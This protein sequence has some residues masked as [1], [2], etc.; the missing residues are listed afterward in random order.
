VGT[1]P[2]IE[3]AAASESRLKPTERASASVHSMNF[4]AD[5][6]I[7]SHYSRATSKDLTLEHLWKWAQIKGVT[8]VATG[9]IAH[10]GWL[11]EMQREVGAGGA[12]AVPL[13]EEFAATVAADLPPTCRGAVRFLLGGEISN[14]Y[15]RHGKTR[16]VHNLIFAPDFDTVARLQTRLERIGNIRADGRPILGLDSRDLLEIALE[17]DAALSLHPRAHLDAVVRHARLD[18]GLRRGGGVLRRPDAAHLCAG[19]RAFLRPADE[20]ARL[21]PGPLHARL[22]LRR[23]FAAE[24]GARGDAV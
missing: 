20:L 22:Q 3:I 11:A 10:P 4:V 19:D 12:G 7:H 16:K 21:Q 14:I 15:K 5:L 23:A 1:P 2:A 18:V 9:D 17:T 13:K 24:A 6:H 8:V